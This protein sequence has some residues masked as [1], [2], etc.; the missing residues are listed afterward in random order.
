MDQRRRP[1]LV[2]LLNGILGVAEE[3]VGVLGLDLLPLLGQGI[4]LF[5]EAAALPAGMIGADD[6]ASDGVARVANAGDVPPGIGRVGGVHANRGA[7][8]ASL[9]FASGSLLFGSAWVAQH[10]PVG[11]QR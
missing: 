11:R 1:R 2:F 6:Q 7:V 5:V 4:G 8:N 10:K 9:R 3:R